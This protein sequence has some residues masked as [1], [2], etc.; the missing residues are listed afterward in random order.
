VRRAV[1]S[2]LAAT[3]GSGG[4][5]LA[6]GS[7]AGRDGTGAGQG[8]GSQAPVTLNTFSG[9]GDP[10]FWPAQER[11][12]RAFM[13]RHPNITIVDNPSRQDY[14]AKLSAAAAAGTLPDVIKVHGTLIQAQARQGWFVPLDEY[15]ARTRGFDLGDFIK[16]AL[17]LYR[18]SGKLYALPYDHGPILLWYNRDLFDRAGV[19][20]PSA[21]WTLDDLL[22]AAR[23]LTKPGERQWGLSPQFAPSGGTLLQGSMLKPFGGAVVNDDES[24]CLIDAP[25]S[26]QG[27]EW[28]AALRTRHAVTPR[29]DEVGEVAGGIGNVFAA[30]LTALHVEG[31]WVIPTLIQRA[32]FR[33]DVADWPAGPKGRATASMGS[34]YGITRDSKARD[35]AWTYLS[36]FLGKEKDMLMQELATTGR[37]SPARKSFWPAFEKSPGAPPQ[38]GIIAPALEKYSVLGRP[39]SPAAR[40]INRIINEQLAQVWAGKQGVVD[41]ARAARREIDPVL[42]TNR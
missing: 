24:A 9:W 14:D 38:V 27:L 1:L 25:A 19:R 40:D 29:P 5:V 36:E 12:N 23:R 15:V 35:A 3:A 10:A 31:S 7:C 34:G 21:T 16:V 6:A 17:E 28:W 33:W 41:A 20:Y 32:G 37:G 42:A 13:Q 22:E 26:I 11:I 18:V 2:T 30:G 4:L 39:I 8:S